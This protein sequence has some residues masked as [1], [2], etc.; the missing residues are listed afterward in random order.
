[1]NLRLHYSQTIARPSFRELAAIRSYD[2]ILDTLLEGN[3]NLQITEVNN[4]DVRW[5]WF[6]R[7]GELLGV[8]VFAKDLSQPIE[9]SF[10]TRSGDIITFENRPE[11]QV[12]G[13]EFEGRKTLDFIHPS[14]RYVGI[15]GNLS[16]IE[17]EVKLSPNDLK[18]KLEAV[19]G[20]SSTRPLYDQAPYV[21]NVELSYD[22]P[23]IGT[24]VSLNY[25]VAGPRVTIASLN[26]EDVYLQPAPLL[27]FVISQ[28]LTRHLSLRFTA[29]NLLNPELKRTY[30]KDSDFIYSSSTV[31]T[32]FGIS[33]SGE[34]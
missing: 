8:S 14:L 23:G 27:D 2:P 5:E 25:N 34:F 21:L 10:I 26:T 3:P 13:I 18:S 9:R 29:R 6:P 28:R 15:G 17:S 32:T 24:T 30:G 31:G 33:L 19:P 22:N 12:Y 16:L 7:P 20:A 1:M 11:A 4:Y